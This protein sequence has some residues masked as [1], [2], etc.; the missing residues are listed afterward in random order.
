MSIN[1]AIKRWSLFLIFKS[2]SDDRKLQA[3]SSLIFA[4]VVKDSFGVAF[5]ACEFPKVLDFKVITDNVYILML[6]I[7]FGCLSRTIIRVTKMAKSYTQISH[8]KISPKSVTNI[9]EARKYGRDN[10][11][12]IDVGDGMCW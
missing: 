6:A 9:D 3:S 10:N 5:S 4:I 11:G 7:S 12:Y 2:S 1:T 8:Q